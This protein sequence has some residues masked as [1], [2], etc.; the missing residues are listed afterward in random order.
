MNICVD[1]VSLLLLR[2]EPTAS[3]T[4]KG[5]KSELALLSAMSK[6]SSYKQQVEMIF[7]EYRRL[8]VA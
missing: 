3:S 7:H 8:P 2:L 6:L 5:P 4:E 1:L